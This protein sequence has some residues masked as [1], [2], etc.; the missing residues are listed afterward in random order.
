MKKKVITFFITLVAAIMATTIIAYAGNS[1]DTATKI[2]VDSSY[3]SYLDYNEH[4]YYVFTV[5]NAGTYSIYTTS[6]LDTYGTLYDGNRD[7]VTAADYGGEDGNFKISEYLEAGTYYVEVKD[8]YGN[9][10]SYK[11][12]VYSPPKDISNASI[13]LSK[14]SYTY[15]GTYKKPVVTVK[16]GGK[17]LYEGDDYGVTY[18][19]CK[20]AGRATVNITGRGKYTGTA[21]RYYTINRRSIAKA[22]LKLKKSTYTY[23][24]KRKK[25]TVIL[26]SG[27]RTLKKGTDYTVS[28]KNNL[29]KGTATATVTAKGNYKGKRTI[30]FKIK[31]KKVKSCFLNTYTYNGKV[32]T[33]SVHY[34][35]YVKYY[36]SYYDTYYTDK[37]E[38]TYKRGRDYKMTIKGNHKNIGT[39]TCK[40]KFKGN[41]TGTLTRKFKI[42]PRNVKSIRTLKRTKTAV[43][44]K[45]TKVKG[46]QG[47]RV[48]RYN[49][50]ILGYSFY[51]KVKGTSLNVP[52]KSAKDTDVAIY[53]VAYKTVKG[54]NYVSKMPCYYLDYLK[55]SKDSF[56]ITR[57]GF[58]DFTVTFTMNTYHEIQLATDKKFNGARTFTVNGEAF[59]F[60]GWQSGTKYYI[61]TRRFI[62]NR[63]GN[64]EVGP[65][66]KVKTV[67]P[68]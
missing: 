8:Y 38:C 43:K 26:K 57:P 42:I 6:S 5:F 46:A 36:D 3:S 51:K 64:L 12:Y 13:T 14:T 34:Y 32:K 35:K 11:L 15:D 66:S 30:K 16:Y 27:N 50:Q 63:Q 33:P 10:G 23:N 61:R 9:S 47:Y 58:G 53:V 17:T 29:N 52:R 60:Y 25:P 20:S 62:Y 59:Y 67:R 39:Y 31:A 1:F 65:W 21:H 49:N 4:E 18:S 56:K 44:F 68:Y 37:K 28:Y 54:K 22:S 19:H 2:P 24:G 45:W 40:I 48:Y 41:Y 55:P 7:Y